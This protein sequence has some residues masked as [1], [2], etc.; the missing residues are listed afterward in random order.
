MRIQ[1]DRNDISI[2]LEQETF[3]YNLYDR[4]TAFF[5]MLKSA[6]EAMGYSESEILSHISR[7]QKEEAKGQ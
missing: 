2:D 1:L 7:P 3:T 5:A 4:D 6:L